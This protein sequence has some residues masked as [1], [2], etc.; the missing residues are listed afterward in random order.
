[1]VPL[2][3]EGHG[4]DE[5]DK[6]AFTTDT[7]VKEAIASMEGT[8]LKFEDWQ[9]LATLSTRRFSPL[10][11]RPPETR[12]SLDEFRTRG[13]RAAASARGRHAT[14]VAEAA[15]HARVEEAACFLRL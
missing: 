9:P 4:G 8:T 14:A 1:M 15:R 13:G 3:E 2:H 10:G 6:S 11:E 12:P 7:T 5:G